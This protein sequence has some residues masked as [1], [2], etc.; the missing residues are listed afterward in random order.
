MLTKWT[1]LEAMDHTG[2]ELSF[3]LYILIS[4]CEESVDVD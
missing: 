4:L 3:K 2:E 1:D